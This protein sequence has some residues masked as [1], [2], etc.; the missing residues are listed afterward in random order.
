VEE[1]AFAVGRRE[2]DQ[3]AVAHGELGTDGA[4]EIVGDAGGFVDD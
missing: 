1:A 2:A 3:A 4:V